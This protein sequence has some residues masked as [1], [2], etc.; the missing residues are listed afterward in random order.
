MSGREISF[1]S[2]L[3]VKNS[4]HTDLKAVSYTQFLGFGRVNN[5]NFQEIAKICHDDIFTLRAYFDVIHEN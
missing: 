2:L 5:C 4:R 1:I 3:L